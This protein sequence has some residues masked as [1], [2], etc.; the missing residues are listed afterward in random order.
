MLELRLIEKVTCTS[1][2]FGCGSCFTNYYWDVIDSNDPHY[3]DLIN[4]TLW[5]KPLS[6]QE[7][8]SISEWIDDKILW[9][10]DI[11]TSRTFE[12]GEWAMPTSIPLSQRKALDSLIGEILKEQISS[13]NENKFSAAA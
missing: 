3:E 2:Q 7:I 10:E 4:E 6:P 11:H 9:K 1:D 13:F 12:Y 8:E 5:V